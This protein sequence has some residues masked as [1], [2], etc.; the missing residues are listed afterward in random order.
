MDSMFVS[1]LV[2]EFNTHY[3]GLWTLEF[4]ADFFCL[5]LGFFCCRYQPPIPKDQAKPLADFG[6]EGG[7]VQSVLLLFHGIYYLILLIFFFIMYPRG[8]TS[9]WAR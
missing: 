3:F 9:R 7:K 5:Y 6:Y 2:L 4:N 1:R 8:F